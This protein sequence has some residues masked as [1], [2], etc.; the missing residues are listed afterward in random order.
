MTKEQAFDPLFSIDFAAKIIKDGKED[1][2]YT[3]CNCWQ[4]V[5]AVLGTTPSL[6]QKTTPRGG[7]IAVFDYS[8]T[9]HYAVVLELKNDGFIVREANYEPCKTGT[10]LIKWGDTHIKGFY[11]PTSALA[12]LN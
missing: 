4:Y 9:P 3:S 6:T 7:S 1:E 8:G 10:R 5:K 12:T 2:Q 11:D